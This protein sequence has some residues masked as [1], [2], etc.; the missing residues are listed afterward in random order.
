MFPVGYIDPSGSGEQTH[1]GTRCRG[2]GT[3]PKSWGQ[4][5]T[6]LKIW[7][8]KKSNRVFEKCAWIPT[9][10]NAIPVT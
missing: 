7:G 9:T 2:H 8:R 1:L 4:E 6:K 5:S 3:S 10:A